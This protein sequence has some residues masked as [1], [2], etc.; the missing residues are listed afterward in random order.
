MGAVGTGKEVLAEVFDETLNSDNIRWSASVLRNEEEW[1]D[2]EDSNE[3][4]NS[5]VPEHVGDLEVYNFEGLTN[6]EVDASLDEIIIKEYD[7]TGIQV[8]T[9]DRNDRVRVRQEGSTLK[10][11][12]LTKE[13]AVITVYYPSKTE[14][15]EWDLEVGAGSIYIENDLSV[16]ELDIE[17][18]AGELISEGVLTVR[19]M[20][21]DVG[22]GDV[23]IHALDAAVLEAE[24][25]MGKLEI[26][27][28]G[29]ESDYSY[30]VECGMGS[31]TVGDNN[32]SG[33]SEEHRVSNANAKKR[34]ELE[35]GMGEINVSFAE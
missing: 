5:A 34:M 8:E 3:W 26:N 32:Y 18:G 7:G 25:G 4:N 21:I 1:E 35:C 11:K 2:L 31:L 16:N 10:I 12:S 30:N 13:G 29:Q 23:N 28:V 24:C 22:A 17:V 33:I 14:F 6:L 19:E 20:N 9:D 27:A 15:H